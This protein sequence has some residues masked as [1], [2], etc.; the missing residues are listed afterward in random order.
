MKKADIELQSDYIIT[1]VDDMET[2]K[3][4]KNDVDDE[5]TPEQQE[6]RN[7]LH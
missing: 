6:N 5:F 3:K 2:L 7:Q 1:A 4:N